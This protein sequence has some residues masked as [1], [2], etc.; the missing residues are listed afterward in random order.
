MDNKKIVVYIGDA[1]KVSP[2]PELRK[3]QVKEL[4]HPW[5]MPSKKKYRKEVFFYD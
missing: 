2:M 5:W 4:E 1:A 3:A